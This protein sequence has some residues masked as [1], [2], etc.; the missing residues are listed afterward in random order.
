MH[1]AFRGADNIVAVREQASEISGGVGDDVEDVPDIFCGGEGSPLES[2]TEG[3]GGCGN[4]DVENAD[5][6][7]L[8]S[9]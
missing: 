2:K 5:A 6:L 3:G 1:V 8:W 7:S 4:G 9:K